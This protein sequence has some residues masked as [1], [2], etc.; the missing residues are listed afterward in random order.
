MRV[1]DDLILRE[2]AGQYVI[3]PVGKRVQE[4]TSVVYMTK[5]AADLWDYMTTHDFSKEDLIRLTMEK[6]TDVT[7]ERVS[8]DLDA[9]LKNLQANSILEIDGVAQGSFTFFAEK[10]H[11]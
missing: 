8:E 6:Y 3:V 7:E 2:V 9:F 4:V 1:K 11:E 10:K 5:P